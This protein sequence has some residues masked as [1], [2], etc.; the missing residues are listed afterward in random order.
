MLPFSAKTSCS[1]RHFGTSTDDDRQ[2]VEAKATS[3]KG[4]KAPDNKTGRP[5]VLNR[6]SVVFVVVFLVTVVAVFVLYE[7]IKDTKPMARYVEL[8]SGHVGTVLRLSG[9]DTVVR[10][11]RV[12]IKLDKSDAS[13]RARRWT[14]QVIPDCGAI[15]SMAIFCAAVLAFPTGLRRKLLG[16]LI[17]VPLLY[18]VNVGRLVCLGLV[19]LYYRSGFHFAHVYVWQ[20]IFIVFVVVIWM[21]WVDKVAKV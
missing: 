8:I 2:S 13:K 7:Y 19:G 1:T 16:V 4:S 20:S 6:E 10:G 3:E 21:V 18:L 5:S 11:D 14:M 9:R 15:P 12:T 17:G